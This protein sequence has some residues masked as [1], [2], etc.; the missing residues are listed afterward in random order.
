MFSK[1]KEQLL[2]DLINVTKS[3]GQGIPQF[4]I[5]RGGWQD[6]ADELIDEGYVTVHKHKEHD[7]ALIWYCYNKVYNVEKDTYG[8]NGSML[9][10][11][12]MRHYLRIDEDESKGVLPSN[13]EVVQANMDKYKEWLIENLEGLE[14]IKNLEEVTIGTELLDEQK[15]YLKSRGWYKDNLTIKE[16]LEKLIDRTQIIEELSHNTEKMIKLMGEHSKYDTEKKKYIKELEEYKFQLKARKKLYSIMD[17]EDSNIKV[18][19][20]F[21]DL[22]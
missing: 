8:F 7:P 15:E 9:Y 5:D 21:K 13:S 12:F 11:S 2:N 16:S 18:K 10:Y 20:V 14:A 4:V 17:G 1:T 19:E 3:S 22:V 6:I